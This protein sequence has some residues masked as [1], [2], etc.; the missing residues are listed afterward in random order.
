[1]EDL[2]GNNLDE[3]YQNYRDT[4]GTTYDATKQALEQQRKNDFATIMAG[5]NKAG[6]LY[7]SWAPREK[8]LYDT[9]TYTPALVKAQQSYQTG[10]NTLRE[11]ALK[12]VNNIRSLQDQIAHINSLT[13]GERTGSTG[14]TSDIAN[15]VVNR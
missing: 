6:M 7:S 11:N 9:Q 15:T 12:A 2:Q 3:F 5:A 4:I 8:I 1:M 10:L 14:S 13:V